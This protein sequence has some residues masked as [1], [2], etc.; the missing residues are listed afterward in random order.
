VGKPVELFRKTQP[1]RLGGGRTIA[2]DVS[3]DGNRFLLV[4]PEQSA[5]AQPTVVVLN[6]FEELRARA[7]TAGSAPR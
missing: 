5:Q 3:A 6:W 4:V 2:Y 1:D 7:R